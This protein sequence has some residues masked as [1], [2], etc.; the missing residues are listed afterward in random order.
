MKIDYININK[1]DLYLLST[2]AIGVGLLV[3]Y[4]NIKSKIILNDS[5]V[6]KINSD[7]H[8]S[9]AFV[10]KINAETYKIN[11]DANKSNSIIN[12]YNSTARLIDSLSNVLNAGANTINLQIKQ[13]EKKSGVYLCD[14][15]PHYNTCK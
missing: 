3:T 5:I 13:S 12:I 10:K 9:D 7:V 4:N 14:N 1:N 11:S 8:I 6:N 15:R 2:C